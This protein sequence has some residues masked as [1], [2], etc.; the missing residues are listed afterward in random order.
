VPAFSYKATS[1]E[2]TVIEGVIEAPE[3]SVVYEKLR[4]SG[5]IPLHVTV[6]R[7]K[8]SFSLSRKADL[9]TFT[10][11]LSA[12][13]G[14]GL[15]LDR[16]LNILATVGEESMTTVVESV[17][18]SIREGKS[19][20]E[21]LS[22]HPKVFPS[23]YVNMVRA[24][25]AGGVVDVV[26]EKLGEFQES[27]KELRDHIF[28]AMIYPV[29]LLVTGGLSVIL[30]LTF[31]LPRFS[32]IFAEM[33]TSL[34]LPTQIL[35]AISAAAQSY[36]WLGLIVIIGGVFAFR[37]STRTPAGTL[38]WDGLKLKLFRDVIEKLE[39]ARFCRTLGTLLRSGVSLLQALKNSRDVVTNS[40]MA[41]ALETVSKGAKEGRGI[42][43]P[44]AAAKVFPP[45][46]LSMIQ[47]GEETGQLDAMLLKVAA[48]YERSLKEAIKRLISFLEPA[49]ILAMAL[50][51][52]FI[53]VA[54]LMAIFSISDIPV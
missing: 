16:S 14:A 21:A 48:T 27:T 13:L 47:V 43:T 46:A 45:L 11:E 8:R 2:G 28:S 31:V 12:L 5:V 4:A 42:A 30:L 24:G 49:I 23:L 17:L 41:S 15:P 26:L 32:V 54:M 36:W 34:P 10:T 40:V 39:T 38:W 44:L 9:L 29:I 19:F 6:P 52:G 22:R 20:S 35:L 25:E 1:L 53:V 18:A 50:I 51:I 7:A 37:A 3:E 33:G